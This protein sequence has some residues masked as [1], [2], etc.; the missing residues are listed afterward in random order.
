MKVRPHPPAHPVIEALGLTQHDVGLLTGYSRQVVS[1]A[2]L[3]GKASPSFR[4]TFLELVGDRLFGPRESFEMF[5]TAPLIAYINRACGG[6]TPSGWSQ[7]RGLAW[8]WL[9]RTEE[10]TLASADRVCGI[11]GVHMSEIWENAA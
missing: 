8:D 1:D 5:P 9:N 2:L 4:D 7:K 11:L 6:R 10:I 3:R